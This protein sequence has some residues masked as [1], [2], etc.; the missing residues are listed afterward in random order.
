MDFPLLIVAQNGMGGELISMFVMFGFIFLI[1]W[2]ILIRPQKK[3]MERHQE[4]LSGL[5]VGDQ[6]VTAGGVF[7]TIKSVDGPVIQLE[8]GGGTKI[9]IDREK[10]QKTQ[11]EFFEEEDKDKDNSSDDESGDDDEDDGEW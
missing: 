8:I 10:V 4:L 2:F 3:E 1:F 9:K 6:V 11:D 5:K 7:G